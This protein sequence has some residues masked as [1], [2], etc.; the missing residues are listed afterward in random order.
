MS[1]SEARRAGVMERVA[2]GELRQIE[3]AEIL[4][5]SYR[6]TKRLYQR[7]RKQGV[8][9]LVHG[10]AGKR[11]Q[12]AKPA[13]EKTRVL[14]LVRQHYG[15]TIATRFGP[16]LIA[17]HLLADHGIALDAETVRRWMLAE[18][19]WSRERKR[20][21]YRQ[22]RA[23]R[24]HF[25]ELVQMDGSFENWL[26]ERGPRGCLINM[27]DDATSRGMI[28]LAAEE[29]TWAVADA[30]RRWV[31][32]HGIPRA[33]YVDWKNVY[34]HAPTERQER[35]GEV[36]VSQFQRMCGKLGIEVIGANS[37]QAKG[38]VE[39]S[40][41]IH[42][43]RL[44]KKL[45]LKRIRSYAAANEYLRQEYERQHNDKYAVTAREAVDFHEEVPA[46]LDLNQVFCLEQ[47]R[48]VSN[49][50]VVQYGQRWLQIGRGAKVQPGTRVV[51]R[52]YRDGSI[53]LFQGAQKLAWEEIETRA[54]GSQEKREHRRRLKSRFQPKGNH[55]WRK[56]LALGSRGGRKKGTF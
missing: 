28:E 27:V 13:K 54:G 43:D 42:Q 26:E 24:A 29:T 1:K 38:R 49:D 40:H 19:L 53:G 11:S 17:E 21:S 44:I 9:G 46:G 22:R 7:Y 51:V 36:P 45:R 50:W 10:N 39:R 6:Q 55:P 48:T 3:A 25:G 8:A 20:K 4:K 12:H 30:L 56:P 41:G 16:T 15:G 31:E 37:P 5:L 52:E 35:D 47:E 18:G 23:R 34:H 32:T 33:L 2:K 14:K